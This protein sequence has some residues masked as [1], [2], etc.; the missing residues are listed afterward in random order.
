MKQVGGGRLLAVSTWQ[1]EQVKGK[2]QKA[3]KGAHG[4]CA[5]ESA[6]PAASAAAQ[7]KL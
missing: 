2:E 1:Q 7:E 5:L 4:D 6:D 3:S